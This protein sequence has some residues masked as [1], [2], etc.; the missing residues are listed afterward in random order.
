MLKLTNNALAMLINKYRAVLKKMRL[1]GGTLLLAA[2]LLVPMGVS[3]ETINY[4][5]TNTSVF[6]P[7]QDWL[8]FY[9]PENIIYSTSDI[10]GNVI[11]I[12][13][14]A[15]IGSPT[16][17]EHILGGASRNSAVYDNTVKFE[18]GRLLVDLY[19][20]YSYYANADNNEVIITG[21]EING[22][23]YGG[24]GSFANTANN[25]I[26]ITGGKI[27]GS[28]YGGYVSSGAGNATG[29]TVNINANTT[30]G[31]TGKISGGDYYA[32]GTGGDVF[33]GNTLN[34][35]SQIQISGGSASAVSVQNFETINFGY[36][37]N[38]NIGVLDTTAGGSAKSG[39]VMN[40]DVNN[41]NFGGDI[42]GTG[43]LEKTGAG[44]LTFSGNNTYSGGTT[45]S[46]G[47][48]QIGDGGAT[49]S[50]TGNIVNNANVIFNRSDAVDYLGN[51]SGA[52]SLTKTG[53]GTLSLFGANNYNGDTVINEGT[54][55]GNIADNTNLTVATAATYAG[56][57]T[58]RSVNALYGG[59]T[60]TD[61]NG[62]TIQSGDFSGNFAATGALTKTGAGVLTLTGD[63]YN[64]GTTTVESGKLVIGRADEKVGFTATGDYTTK[65]NATTEIGAGSTLQI[66]GDFTQEENAELIL[67]ANADHSATI[68]VNGDVSLDGTYQ[69]T[70]ISGDIASAKASELEK[71]Y[72]LIE[73]RGDGHTITDN[74]FTN[75]GSLSLYLLQESG[76][77]GDQKSYDVKFTLA[78]ND[79]VGNA[80][81]D[82]TVAD[83][84]S[85]EV[86]K[87]LKNNT[88][89]DST[90]WDGESLN[91][92]GAGELILS[93]VN[94]YT[95]TTTVSEGILTLSAA[96][97]IKAS[98][99]VEVNS[100]GQIIFANSNQ[101]LNNISG[102]GVIDLG[103]NDLTAN[104]TAATDF[105]G[106]IA[107]SGN[108]AKTGDS[109]LL[110]SGDNSYSGD[111][112]VNAGTLAGNIAANTNLTVATNAAYDGT[113][114]ARQVNALNGGGDVINTD[115]LIAQS[116]NFSGE[117][118]GAGSLTKTGTGTLTLSG[119]NSY[120]GDTIVNAGTLEGTIAANSNLTVAA[121]ATYNSFGTTR[122]INTL[123][124]GGTISN[125]DSLTVQSG[126]FSGSLLAAGD[127]AKTGAGVLTLTGDA[128]NVGATTV[129]SGKLTLGSTGAAVEFT[130]TGGYTTENATT[131]IGA[132]SKLQVNGEFRQEENAALILTA[133]ADRSA[134]ISVD[135]DVSLDGTYQVRGISSAGAPAKASDFDRDDNKYVL[136]ET[137]GD[138]HTITDNGFTNTSG[139]GPTGIDY[140]LQKGGV[141]EDQKS[142][143]VK[144]S[145]AWN[146]TAGNAI[147]DF[148]VADGTSFEVDKELKN[149]TSADSAKWD[150]ASLNKNGAGELIFSEV[151]AYTGTTTVNEGVLTLNAADAIKAS[152][153]VEVN[154]G[155]EIVFGG[156]DQTLNNIAG[157]GTI[158]LSGNGNTLTANNT[159]DTIFA[160]EITGSGSLTK[161]GAGELILGGAN[162]YAGLTELRGGT[163]S[164]TSGGSI[165]PFLSMYGGTTFN[166]GG[167]SVPLTNLNVYGKDAT[168]SGDLDMAN[169]ALNFFLPSD[170]RS[171][172]TMLTVTGTADISGSKVNVDAADTAAPLDLKTGDEVTLI[173]TETAGNLRHTGAAFTVS[174]GVLTEFNAQVTADTTD[175]KLTLQEEKV[176]P[177]AKSM[178]E[179]KAANLTFL[180]QGA[181]LI[182]NT[183]SNTAAS[184]NAGRSAGEV[185]QEINAAGQQAGSAAS[186]FTFGETGY[187]SSRYETGSHLDSN[188]TTLGVGVG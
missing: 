11:T 94:A 152:S 154:S 151:N 115:G 78:W 45:V 34:L 131:E 106:V 42:S 160:G 52:G 135:G 84:T 171:G 83:S 37:G 28:I 153:E 97:A 23:V 35:N 88:S 44:T 183:I 51:I 31:A 125:T 178:L 56:N 48:L 21:G 49:G 142:Y 74:G 134:T 13:Y 145:L 66:E 59:G 117:I 109:T 123:N 169:R 112:I 138:G 164:L 17:P 120:S 20:G 102:A 15:S 67:T 12:N 98:S 3:G 114:A 60:I 16:H 168:W 40:T 149:N 65:E 57:S 33:T 4:D 6:S 71:K 32:S 73:T 136:I 182:A 144:F 26:T 43:S 116:G 173:H 90:K 14:D 181:D 68:S 91:K 141:S 166:T 155:G 176:K 180:N 18:N 2:F 121:G 99:K 146:D 62:L 64:V 100:G 148:T 92:N 86:D 29:N 36:S 69:V 46:E 157:N 85:F 75:T 5:G 58:T 27:R 8:P 95:G 55:A 137:R 22:S 89:A 87:E 167:N 172:D 9:S 10:T 170:V 119:D 82:F 61:T 50:I 79:T 39:V 185:S 53:A 76:V 126:N 186:T 143:D 104:N 72:V 77:S 81:G 54:L 159:T 19:G 175:L 105:G 118:S 150:G 184:L 187:G 30:L 93:E 24:Y 70:G 129:E 124:G 140:L 1:K 162:N 128:Y 41:I 158:D 80:I 25:E 188:G 122:Q 147:G 177:E 165:S 108:L 161:T 96:D 156:N 132:G 7:Y 47:A 63:A 127:L 139:V 103:A 130:A 113:G 179:G 174:P 133:N 107:G 111:T 38:A 110:L 163:L 101:T